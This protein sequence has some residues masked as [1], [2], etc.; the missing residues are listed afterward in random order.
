MCLNSGVCSSTIL[1]FSLSFW[2]FDNIT[3]LAGF[4]DNIE[5]YDGLA[6]K[7]FWLLDVAIAD[8]LVNEAKEEEVGAKL[9]SLR[10]EIPAFLFFHLLCFLMTGV[11]MSCEAFWWLYVA[12][13]D[14]FVNEAK[15]EEV[16]AEWSLLRFFLFFHLLC[17]LTIGVNMS[18]DDW[19]VCKFNMAT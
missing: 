6:Y 7:A 11:N 12:I 15:E 14:E 19:L 3:I 2:T 16:G 5:E 10:F 13:A 8:E 4:A 9:S 17:L 18:S 1:G